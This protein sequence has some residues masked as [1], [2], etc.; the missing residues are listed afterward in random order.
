MGAAFA[1]VAFVAGCMHS[2][3]GPIQA[4]VRPE[5]PPPE[6]ADAKIAPR[7]F[8]SMRA[9]LEQTAAVVEGD[10]SEVAF[11]FDDCAG[12]RTNIK[13]VNARSVLGTAVANEIVLSVFGGPMPDG[14]WFQASELPRVALGARYV[15]LLRNTD[16]KFA[17][18]LGSHAYRVETIAG[19]S[20]L[21]NALGQ[22]VTGLSEAGI[23]TH[24]DALTEP[25]G[26]RRRALRPEARRSGQ[27][28]SDTSD[29]SPTVLVAA[30]HDAS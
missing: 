26:T 9:I 27:A 14:R 6:K 3:H 17:P 10:V 28:E 19:R 18:I 8:E 2:G 22:A 13:V 7:A 25:T 15:F 4:D 29:R 21:V 12:P 5:P 16:W 23:E 30:E 24:T 1:A 20:V 11:G